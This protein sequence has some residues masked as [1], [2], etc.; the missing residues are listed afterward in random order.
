MNIPMTR[1]CAL[2]LACSAVTL[3]GGCA[4]KEE[5]ITAAMLRKDP[6]PNMESL[7][8][9]HEERLNNEAESWNI[10]W[11]SAV[12]TADRIMFNDRPHR[13]SIHPIP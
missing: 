13:M 2:I 4:A 8:F 6:S 7:A 10:N 1:L 9:T 5:P 3:S 11:R 12:G